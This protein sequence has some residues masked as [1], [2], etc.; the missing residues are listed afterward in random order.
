MEKNVITL[1]QRSQDLA[2]QPLPPKVQ[3]EKTA[4]TNFMFE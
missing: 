4:D 2:R 1:T 3:G